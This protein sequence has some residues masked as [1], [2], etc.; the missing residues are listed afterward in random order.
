[1][2]TVLEPPLPITARS[3]QEAAIAA[4]RKYMKKKALLRS[5]VARCILFSISL[6]TLAFAQVRVMAAE[7][8]GTV[9]GAHLPIG[10]ST[11]TLYAASTGLPTQL[12]EG[13]TDDDG[14]F[15]LNFDQT[16]ADS[17]FYLV[18]K[19]GTPKAAA[20][21]SPNDAIALLAVIGNPVAKDG[22]G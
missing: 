7:L 3:A 11:V 15:H 19:G 22:H 16:P 12:A 17:V 10:G 13:K 18:A 8:A 9:Q 14:A 4:A 1:M 6:F 20:D 21:K 2:P 5:V